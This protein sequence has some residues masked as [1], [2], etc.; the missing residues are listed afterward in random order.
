MDRHTSFSCSVFSWDSSTTTSG[1]SDLVMFD[2]LLDG[3]K[4]LGLPLPGSRDSAPRIRSTVL[5]RVVWISEFRLLCCLS[6]QSLAT[7]LR[8]SWGGDLT[9]ISA[10]VDRLWGSWSL[11]AGRSWPMVPLRVGSCGVHPPCSF[12]TLLMV[13][14]PT[15]P[16]IRRD[17]RDVM[18]TLGKA[19]GDLSRSFNLAYKRK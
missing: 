10:S 12:I 1:S 7:W 14:F 15:P 9:T 11:H 6:S 4:L 13:R 16:D 19:C 8:K 18:I 3:M 2:C 17:E 5:P